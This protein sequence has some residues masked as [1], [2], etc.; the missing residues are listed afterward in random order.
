MEKADGA[1][2]TIGELARELGVAQHILRY[3]ESRFTQL[4]PLQRSG[5][6][7]YYRPQDVEIA[8]RIHRLLNLE[9]FTIKGAIKALNERA[10][11]RPPASTASVGE[12]DVHPVTDARQLIDRLRSIRA[13]L[14]EAITGI[15]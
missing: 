9:G 4:R 15:E 13:E 7:R 6:R 11:L 2:L 10:D 3:W 5:N 14:A 12:T 8:R 1:F